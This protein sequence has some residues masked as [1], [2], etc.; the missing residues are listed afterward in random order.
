[1]KKLLYFLYFIVLITACTKRKLEVASQFVQQKDSSSIDVSQNFEELIIDS[2]LKNCDIAVYLNMLKEQNPTDP[3][4]YA[5]YDSINAVCFN[6]IEMANR[7]LDTIV[8]HQ[9]YVCTRKIWTSGLSEPAAQKW[10]D[11]IDKV[12]E[13]AK[14]LRQNVEK[15]VY[16]SH[17][18]S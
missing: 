5:F 4:D 13:N 12:D 6:R 15:I 14:K 18:K 11:S 3:K 7:D 10:N 1:M 16:K 8:D 9:R 17:R 2:V